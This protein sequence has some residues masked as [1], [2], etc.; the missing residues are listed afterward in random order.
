MKPI[1]C[2][3]ILV[4]LFATAI[5]QQDTPANG[6]IYGVLIGQDGQPSKGIGLTA[7]PLG[8]ATVSVLPHTSSDDTGHYRFE[9]LPWWGRY[10]VYADDE[11]AGYSSISTGPAGKRHIPEVKITPQHPRAEFTVYLPPKAGFLSIHLRNRKTGAAISNMEITV[12]AA[13]RPEALVFSEGC[14]SD[15]VILLPPDKNLLLHVTSKGFQEWAAS[16]DGGKLI[17]RPAASRL[18][19]DVQLEPRE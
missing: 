6:V 14:S 2:A 8:V 9:R 4:L 10:T 18:T 12:M 3:M 15:H 7:E 13:Q 11:N 16:V 19:L 1:T 5:A 17:N